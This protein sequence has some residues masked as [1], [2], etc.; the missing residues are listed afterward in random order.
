[1]EVV[2]SVLSLMFSAVAVIVAYYSFVRTHKTSIMPVLIFVRRSEKIWQIQNVGKGP[3]IS[4][5]IGDKNRNDEWKAL[6]QF[7]PIA[8]GASLDLPW[9]S[10]GI[11]LGAVYTDVKGNIYSSL[12]SRNINHIFEHNEFPDW[13]ASINWWAYNQMPNG[14]QKHF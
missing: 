2:L 8:A 12:C 14:L 9:Q 5:K 3:A 4:V 11:E 7:Y 1:M 13:E 6:T 10:Y